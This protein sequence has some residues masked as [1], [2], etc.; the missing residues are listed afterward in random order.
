MAPNEEKHKK[1]RVQTASSTVHSSRFYWSTTQ[2]AYEFG[3][4]F[5]RHLE[6]PLIDLS[7]VNLS[8]LFCS[9]VRLSAST[10]CCGK[11]SLF[12]FKP[13]ACLSLCV[14]KRLL[15]VI[16]PDCKLDDAIHWGW[17]LSPL[18][19]ARFQQGVDFGCSEGK[20][21]CPE[22]WV[23]SRQRA[24]CHGGLWGTPPVPQG[25][26]ATSFSHIYWLTSYRNGRHRHG[27]ESCGA[28]QRFK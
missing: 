4:A 24:S 8:K 26:T 28:N 2:G 25:T 13:A 19:L 27:T 3:L 12:W 9:P 21:S 14:M 15:S 1:K 6:Q 22:D 16:L 10:T 17:R 18:L 5:S 20:H 7:S 11:K 23:Q